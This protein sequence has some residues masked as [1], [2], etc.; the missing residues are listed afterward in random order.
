MVETGGEPGSTILS[1]RAEGAA[2]LAA[3]KA[4]N[5]KT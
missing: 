1:V 4:E 2:S 5:A 3:E